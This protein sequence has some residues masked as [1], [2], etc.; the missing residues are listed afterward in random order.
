MSLIEVD[1][2]T[3]TFK[4]RSRRDGLGAAFRRLLTPGWE[5]KSAVRDLTFRIDEGEIV[6][7]LGPNGAGKSTTVKCLAGILCPTRGTV[8]V[9]GMDPV[10]ERTRV[11]RQLGV[12]FGQKTSLW[13]DVPVIETYRLIRDIY[14]VAPAD[15]ARTLEA[16]DGIMSLGEFMHLPV[17]Q[18]SLGQRMRADLGAAF[19]YRPR[20]L[21]LDEPTIGLDV[22]AKSNLRQFIRQLRVESGVTILMTTHD[23]RDIE[24]L[25]DRIMIIDSGSI[26]FDGTADQLVSR[27]S[28]YSTAVLHLYQEIDSLP[29]I[30]GAEL[31][32]AG[33][34]EV[35][36][37]FRRDEKAL[38]DLAPVLLTGLPVRDFS[39]VEP[40]IDDVIRDGS[41]RPRDEAAERAR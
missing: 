34:L 17:R 16:L 3:K 8:R 21:F 23:L 40:Q 22:A 28:P 37:R 20:L 13:W 24:S 30:A 38:A 41:W 33:P 36:A 25:C 27:F 4:V 9:A 14:G 18:L 39:V 10:R 7:Y 15:Y 5:V 31:T 1:Q 11:A 26:V 19:L 32:L 6:G 29:Y 35:R 2:L 12:V